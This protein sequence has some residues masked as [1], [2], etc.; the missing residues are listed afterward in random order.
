[1]TDYPTPQDSTDSANT[2]SSGH[3]WS[4][5][6]ADRA[7]TM[8][9]IDREVA[10][11]MEGMPAGDMAALG[12]GLDAG[13]AIAPG[14]ELIGT[15]VQ[16]SN[17]DVFLEFGG[18]SLGIL[19][20]N[21]FGKKEAVEPGRKVDVTVDQYDPESGL[22]KVNRKGAITRATWTNLT[23]G[24]IV[25]GRVTGVIKGGLEI[26]LK[27]IRAFMPGSQVDVAPMKDISVLLNQMVQCEVVELD[28]RHKNVLVSRRK[29]QEKQ[30]AENREKLLAELV[31]G[32]VREGVVGNLMD[33]GAFVDL[34]GVDGL[35]H[36]S[37][38]SWGNVDK[39]SDV[40]TPGQRVEVRVLKIDRERDRISLG[41][42]QTLPDP[43]DTVAARYSVGNAAKVRVTR[44]ADF[45]AFAELE[46][47]IEGLIPL[48]EM[49]WSRVNRSSDAVSAGQMVDAVIIRIEPDKR[50][51]ALSMKQ[52][53]GD[54]WSGVLES[55]APQSIVKGKVTRIADFGAFVEIATGVEGMVHISEMSDKRIKT[56]GEVV[57]VGQELELRVLGV[58]KEQ[59]RI[60]LS[61]KA[62]HAP[63]A[64]AEH[65]TSESAHAMT[66]A[67]PPKEPKKRKKPLR[68]GLSSHISLT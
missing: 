17:D 45:G 31:P 12:M 52:A 39:V 62:V 40:L 28:R 19:P 15:V 53:Q 14:T 42:K 54:P 29:L 4:P 50:R 60:S 8:A 13:G 21:Q 56:C 24:Q 49:G 1:M 26:D 65:A 27:G 5:H 22:L 64:S 33:F 68:G 55:F 47:G 44:L 43:W 35:I 30:R 20:R 41:I 23:R 66:P 3:D 36:I 38:L 9:E 2:M 18:K 57:K 46:G 37:D 7:P 48:S 6:M 61:I 11:A 34:G 16:V 10:E 58:D 51:I 32:Q 63:Q 59:R 67:A 25:E